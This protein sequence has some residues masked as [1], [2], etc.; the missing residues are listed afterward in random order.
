MYISKIVIIRLD[1]QYIEKYYLNNL[2][3]I[4]NI[5]IF[6]PTKTIK[7]GGNTINSATII[8]AK[9]TIT[10]ACGCTIEKQL[11]GKISERES[12]IAWAAEHECPECKKAKY[13]AECQAKAEENNLPSL[14]GS[15]KQTAWAVAIRQ[16]F[17]TNLEN[18]IEKS[19]KLINENNSE[20]AME[21]LA[22]INAIRDAMIANETSASWWIDK[23]RYCTYDFKGM[24]SD[25]MNK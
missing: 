18:W 15:E 8:M 2:Q 12:Y 19:M 4:E 24:I 14:T 23:R 25:Y 11:Y 13:N 5:S 9:Y 10:Y 22:K 7:S 21:S 3:Y 16:T 1:L 17:L 20:K 6:V